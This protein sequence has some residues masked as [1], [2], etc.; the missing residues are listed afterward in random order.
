MSYKNDIFKLFNQGQEKL[1]YYFI[2]LAVTAIGFSVY[3]SG[4]MSLSVWQIPLGVAVVCWALSIYCGITFLKYRLAIQYANFEYLSVSD[5]T[6]PEIRKNPLH[7]EPTKAGI[8]AAI[9]S[10]SKKGGRLYRWQYR[11]FYLGIIAFLTW[12]IVQM[13]LN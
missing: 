10:N 3:R 4:D 9:E 11:Y 8:S 13:S 1:T 2:A 6:H 5:G 12:H 7:A